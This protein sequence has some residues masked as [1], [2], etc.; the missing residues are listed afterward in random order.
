MEQPKPMTALVL[1]DRLAYEFTG[2][3]ET[4]LGHCY[5][6]GEA[7]RKTNSPDGCFR[8]R[9]CDL[10]YTQG[11]SGLPGHL[12][13]GLHGLVKACSTPCDFPFAQGARSAI[14]RRLGTRIQLST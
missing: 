5:T 10:L 12:S 3:F 11:S 7:K 4:P 9:R 14:D 1:S 13:G 2:G 6:G 8:S